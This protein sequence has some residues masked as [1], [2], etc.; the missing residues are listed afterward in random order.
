MQAALGLG[1][2]LMSSVG[3]ASSAVL[4][5]SDG[6]VTCTTLN[7]PTNDRTTPACLYQVSYEKIDRMATITRLPVSHSE[8][9]WIPNPGST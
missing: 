3:V 1:E 5:M 9:G 2:R 8:A 4:R 6:V 7:G